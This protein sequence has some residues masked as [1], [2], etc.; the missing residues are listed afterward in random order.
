M[1]VLTGEQAPIERTL[2]WRNANYDAARV[3]NWKYLIENG[4]EHLFD[5][6]KDLGEK[7]DMKEKE[8]A[9]FA[10]VKAAYDAWNKQVLPRAAAPRGGGTGTGGAGGTGARATGTPPARGAG[11][12]GQRGQNPAGQTG[13]VAPPRGGAAVPCGRG[14]A[15]D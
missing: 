13:Q 15:Q 14:A 7:F 2:F 12:G 6:S 3:G 1:T 4:S 8:P 5:L 9:V 10:K 11:A